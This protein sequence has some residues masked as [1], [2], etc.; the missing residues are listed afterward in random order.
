MRR[1]LVVALLSLCATA[2]GTPPC[3]ETNVVID[4]P[5]KLR[6]IS[7]CTEI[8]GN[9][10]LGSN[11]G[12]DFFGYFRLGGDSSLTSLS[13][14]E[15]LTSVGGEFEIIDND[16]LT[17]LS[18]LEGLTSVGGNLNIYTSSALPQCEADAL[19]ARLAP[20][21]GNDRSCNLYSNNDTGTCQC[22][23]NV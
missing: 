23:D 22:G 12:V 19:G 2:C 13:G 14:L 18:G 11:G 15:G 1:L 20:P 5:D 17:S 9:L 7:G 4:S 21:C 10:R 16:A 8:R 3:E 6:A